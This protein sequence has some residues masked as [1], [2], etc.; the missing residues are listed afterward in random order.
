ML[1]VH[2][3]I[4]SNA[5]NHRLANETTV[6]TE[7]GKHFFNP[8]KGSFDSIYSFALERLLLLHEIRDTIDVGKYHIKIINEFNEPLLE[9]N[10]FHGSLEGKFVLYNSGLKNSINTIGYLK[11]GHLHGDVWYYPSINYKIFTQFKK[12]RK[13]GF[14]FWIDNNG[15]IIKAL[16][17]RR[18]HLINEKNH[19]LD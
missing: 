19:I 18:N 12:G 10:L 3:C 7:D 13:D 5:K 11:N 15:Y 1:L 8:V 14:E 2:F 16:Y 9:V 4:V 17:Y 6:L